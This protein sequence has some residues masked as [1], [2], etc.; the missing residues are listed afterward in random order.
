MSDELIQELPERD[1]SLGDPACRDVVGVTQ[2]DEK[3]GETSWVLRPDDELPVGD[4]L[5]WRILTPAEVSK[6][7]YPGNGSSEPAFN[8]CRSCPVRV[9]CLQ[10]AVDNGDEHG[11]QGGVTSTERK[12]FIK[13]E[14]IT[15]AA[16][17]IQRVE[18]TRKP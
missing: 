5:L 15:D 17:M 7:F 14:G 18:L 16:T 6:L 4:N 11:I 3:G 10:W 9:P 8:L 1:F 13:K 12:D 2:L